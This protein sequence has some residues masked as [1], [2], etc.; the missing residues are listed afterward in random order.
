MKNNKMINPD[1]VYITGTHSTKK[2]NQKYFTNLFPN[3]N[4]IFS[5][6]PKHS[7]LWGALNNVNKFRKYFFKTLN[8]YE[9]KISTPSSN[10]TI[11][12]NT[13]KPIT[14]SR[15][16]VSPNSPR[17]LQLQIGSDSQEI[18]LSEITDDPI[19]PDS[20]L[21]LTFGCSPKYYSFD[22]TKLE[23]IN[24]TSHGRNHS[25]N[26]SHSLLDIFYKLEHIEDHQN[27]INQ[28]F[29]K[30]FMQSEHDSK[31]SDIRS[32]I[33]SITKAARNDITL[34]YV[35]TP[36]E[37]EEIISNISVEFDC[38]NSSIE[39]LDQ[40]FNELRQKVHDPCF[41]FLQELD[42]PYAV[43]KL[44]E[45][46]TKS[47]EKRKTSTASQTAKEHFDEEFNNAKQMIEEIE[48]MDPLQMPKITVSDIMEQCKR[49]EEVT[50]EISARTINIGQ[51]GLSEEMIK[52]LE[53]MGIKVS[54]Q[55]PDENDKG[56]EEGN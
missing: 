28:Y 47:E 35:T 11:K 1:Y 31:C 52:K 25:L 45:M 3:S 50:N 46:L 32:F 49:I 27:T 42:R 15:L 26:I 7:I 56:A 30:K 36:Q 12:I 43:Q 24:Q 21:M 34:A 2:G 13:L 16:Q 39:E 53:K 38:S 54:R 48:N 18:Q 8:P 44:N 51:G 55:V 33:N 41:K 6:H 14:N 10:K 40:I 22:I 23:V 20:S 29:Q 4:V 19:Q 5:R 17:I 37:R 9:T